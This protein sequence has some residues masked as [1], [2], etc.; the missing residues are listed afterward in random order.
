VPNVLESDDPLLRAIADLRVDMNHLIDEQVNSIKE[1]LDEQA[2]P[3]TLRPAPVPIVT[4][5]PDE[6]SKV[7]EIDPRQRLEALAKHLDHRLRLANVPGAERKD[8]GPI[9][10]P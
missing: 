7:R 9:S 5:P 6:T 1:R 10:G 3:R 4:E 8:R 2:Q